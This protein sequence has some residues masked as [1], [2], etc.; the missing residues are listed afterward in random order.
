M[1]R[2][3]I[4]LSKISFCPI[5]KVYLTPNL[6]ACSSCGFNPFLLKFSATLIFFQLPRKS[7]KS[8]KQTFLA[9]SPNC[10]KKIFGGFSSGTFTFCFLSIKI[11]LSI[12]TASPVAGVS[13]L[14]PN[15]FTNPSYRPPPP[16]AK[17]LGS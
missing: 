16:K 10:A 6:S 12:P 17:L 2:I 11:I 4:V 8:F 1:S 9:W 13:S 5:I 15:I 3:I 14:P 7:S